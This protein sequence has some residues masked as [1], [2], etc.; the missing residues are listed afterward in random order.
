M[1][2]KYILTDSCFFH[3]NKKSRSKHWIELVDIE[4]GEVLNLKSGSIVQIV[5]RKK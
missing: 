3:N 4:T 1:K 5:K 2:R